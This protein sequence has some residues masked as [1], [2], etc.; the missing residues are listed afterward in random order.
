MA[1]I[2]K[3]PKASTP[4]TKVK[5]V[6]FNYVQVL[7]RNINVIT[8]L[9]EAGQYY[10]ALQKLLDF[11]NETVPKEVWTMYKDKAQQIRREIG[12]LKIQISAIALDDFNEVI[13]RKKILDK[14]ARDTTASFGREVI[15]T[16]DD[17]GYL[18]ETSPEL[19]MGYDF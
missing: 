19:D 6:Q 9:E 1:E 8:T 10:L 5:K 14:Y 11:V 2:S 18:E 16:L 3:A 7:W 12:F 17:R 4:K 15:N 13:L